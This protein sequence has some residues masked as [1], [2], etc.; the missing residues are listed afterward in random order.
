MAGPIAAGTHSIGEWVEVRGSFNSFGGG[1][2]YRL[3][4]SGNI[5]SGSFLIVGAAGSEM[6]YKF[7]GQR[8]TWEPRADRAL[9]LGT[10][11]IAQTVPPAVWNV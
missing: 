5:Y 11:Q 3:P 1:D 4:R 7:Y 8:I 6:T 2:L 10:A 9:T